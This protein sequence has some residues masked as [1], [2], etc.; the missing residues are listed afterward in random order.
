MNLQNKYKT[1]SALQK[2]WK[3][4]NIT[5]DNVKFPTKEELWVDRYYHNIGEISPEVDYKLFYVS[6]ERKF[7]NALRQAAKKAVPRLLVGNY[8]CTY[9]AIGS[10]GHTGFKF[11]ET[12]DD[13]GD[14]SI[15]LPNYG[16]DRDGDG[17]A[18][19]IYQYPGSLLIRNKFS[20]MEHDYRH[21]DMPYLYFGHYIARNWQANHNGKSFQNA[22]NYATALTAALGGGYHFYTLQNSWI[23]PANSMDIVGNAR[24]IFSNVSKDDS[25]DYIA[26]LTD[27]DSHFYNTIHPKWIPAFMNMRNQPQK[28]IQHS[29]VAFNLFEA[30]DALHKNFVAPKVLFF[31]DSGTLSCQEVAKIRSKWGKDNRVIVW[32]GSPSFLTTKD[33]SAIT[34]ALGTKLVLQPESF[35]PMLKVNSNIKDIIVNGVEGYLTSWISKDHI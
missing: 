12:L 10:W 32:S 14:F 24:K 33:H 9:G 5:F 23:K 27:D 2:A 22:L 20:V 17:M 28:A 31:A 26:I 15:W 16:R 11:R 25:L 8:D 7:K 4:K 34:K 6:G 1:N 30:H 35:T 21:P 18:L 19:T 13:L 29:G 3:K